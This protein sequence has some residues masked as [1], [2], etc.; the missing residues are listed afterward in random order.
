[1]SLLPVSGASHSKH[2]VL[3]AWPERDGTEVDM[4]FRLILRGPLPPNG[5]KGIAEDK[6]RIRRALHPQL[7]AF[8]HQHPVLSRRIEPNPND[9]NAS[10]VQLHAENYSRCGF[11]FVPLVTLDSACALD[12]LILRRQDP[13]KVFTGSGAGDLDGRVKTLLDGLR[14]PQQCS[15]LGGN[16]PEEGE[17]PF[18]VLMADDSVI[19][20]I[21]ITTD[22]LFVPPEPGEA[23]RDIVAVIKVKTRTFSG[24]P[25]SIHNRGP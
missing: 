18:Y 8:W 21:N 1:M 19:Y 3:E 24:D 14:M 10:L 22:R 4:E 12:I 2:L 7:R 25:M 15:E 16:T 11:R 6:H 5:R 23:E 9:P 13:Y 17:D 20:D